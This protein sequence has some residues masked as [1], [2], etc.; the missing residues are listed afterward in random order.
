MV[1]SSWCFLVM[2]K[3]GDEW[4]F[5]SNEILSN[6]LFFIC[7]SSMASRTKSERKTGND[8]PISFQQLF[9]NAWL[10]TT[11]CSER[12]SAVSVGKSLY[13]HP[14]GFGRHLICMLCMFRISNYSATTSTK[15]TQTNFPQKFSF[16]LVTI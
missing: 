11:E 10:R 5:K 4:L 2:P 15:P 6:A 1:F 13:C 12:P 9:V 7:R 3:E 16:D 14:K 8:F